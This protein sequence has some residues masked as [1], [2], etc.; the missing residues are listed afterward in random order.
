DL[1]QVVDGVDEVVKFESGGVALAELRKGDAAAGA[2]PVVGIEDGKSS[3][4]GELS[5]ARITGQPP[6]FVVGLRPTVNHENQRHPF[7]TTA[8]ERVDE[9]P[10]E[11]EPILR[12]ELHNFLPGEP[13]T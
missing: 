8:F 6:I 4:S 10:F 11:L 2:A 12:L 3:G 7:G 13:E 1:D 9:Y 5:E